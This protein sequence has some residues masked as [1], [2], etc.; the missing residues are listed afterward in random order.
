MMPM[1][2]SPVPLAGVDIARAKSVLSPS[3]RELGA[4]QPRPWKPENCIS[5][6]LTTSTLDNLAT[7]RKGAE[8]RPN[9]LTYSASH[10]DWPFLDGG[11]GGRGGD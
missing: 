1:R 5:G 2:S 9:A 7:P 10:S 8:L 3:R 6:C 11:S 4:G